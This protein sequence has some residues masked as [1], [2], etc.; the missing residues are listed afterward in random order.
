MR[1]FAQMLLSR[2]FSRV[3]GHLGRPR[4]GLASHSSRAAQLERGSFP[5]AQGWGS[6]H[7][8]LKCLTLGTPWRQNSRAAICD[9]PRSS[10]GVPECVVLLHYAMT[11][12][13]NTPIPAAGGATVDWTVSSRS[14]AARYVRGSSSNCYM[15]L[16]RWY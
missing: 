9:R 7:Q 8:P 3:R 14:P 1:L 12:Y 13:T 4:S 2:I 5:R 16:Y 15:T 10:A 11:A 6:E